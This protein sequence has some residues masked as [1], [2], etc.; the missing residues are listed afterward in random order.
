[1]TTVL[2]TNVSILG[3]VHVSIDGK[4]NGKEKVGFDLALTRCLPGRGMAMTILDN[5]MRKQMSAGKAGLLRSI[6]ADGK[7][8]GILVSWMCFVQAMKVLEKK[9]R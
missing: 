7:N 6:S 3:R 4:A 9:T 5:D 8:I 2:P 1:M